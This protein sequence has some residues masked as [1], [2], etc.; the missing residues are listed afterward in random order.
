MN[1]NGDSSRADTRYELR[2]VQPHYII[3]INIINAKFNF[4]YNSAIRLLDVNSI[5]LNMSSR[6]NMLADSFLF[7]ISY[8]VNS[9]R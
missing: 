8:T 2:R 1:I 3:Y 6:R 4:S 7:H 9:N 5:Y